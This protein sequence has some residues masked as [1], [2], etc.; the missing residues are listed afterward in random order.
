MHSAQS[1]S[2]RLL[3]MKQSDGIKEILSIAH[4]ELITVFYILYI[5]KKY[6]CNVKN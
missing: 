2:L 6:I 4:L 1:K 3:D 5:E